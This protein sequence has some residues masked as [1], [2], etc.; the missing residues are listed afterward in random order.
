MHVHKKAVGLGSNNLE[1]SVGRLI[2]GGSVLH[3]AVSSERQEQIVRLALQRHGAIGLGMNTA[4][5]KRQH[6]TWSD[7]EM[8]RKSNRIWLINENKGEAE[9]CWK[10]TGRRC[11]DHQHHRHRRE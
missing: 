5:E 6:I 4:N 10:L 11:G 8:I 2:G 3:S 1:A 9:W 7:N